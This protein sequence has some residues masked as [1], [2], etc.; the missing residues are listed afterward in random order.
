MILILTFICLVNLQLIFLQSE[1]IT[2]CFLNITDRCKWITF[3]WSICQD[4][5][6]RQNF[7]NNSEVF[8]RW[9][10]KKVMKITQV[11]N[12]EFIFYDWDII[13]F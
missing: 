12:K 6:K 2:N 13:T 10:L 9:I 3:L 7:V 11:F 8:A 5:I 4:V 1:V